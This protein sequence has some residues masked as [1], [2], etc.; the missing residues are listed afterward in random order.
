MGWEHRGRGAYFYR[1]RRIDGRA[2]KE[3]LGCGP[4]A[5]AA[6]QE[7]MERRAARAREQQAEQQQRQVYDTAYDQLAT[8]V[9]ET[10]AILETAL[11]T[12]GYH[13]PCRGKWRRK[14]VKTKD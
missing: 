14:H 6:A 11:L 13:R 2:V 7:D 5:E 9:H 8:M 10:T 3:Y 1:S 4:V 12:A